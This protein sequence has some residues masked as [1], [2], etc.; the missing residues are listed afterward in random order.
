MHAE[1]RSLDF[2]DGSA[3][4]D[5]ATLAHDSRKW[6]I[7]KLDLTIASYGMHRITSSQ[8]RG[9]YLHDEAYDNCNSQFR[10]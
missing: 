8:V 4:L 9:D 5:D 1:Y 2:H 3:M 6:Y 7:F 10:S